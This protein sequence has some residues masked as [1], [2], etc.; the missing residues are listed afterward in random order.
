MFV[1]MVEIVEGQL[2]GVC[3]NGVWYWGGGGGS[4][5]KLCEQQ[6]LPLIIFLPLSYKL[7][8]IKDKNTFKNYSNK[9]PGT[10]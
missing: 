8:Q 5:A 3:S 2:C 6:M 9:L 1:P 10:S 7:Q 4:F